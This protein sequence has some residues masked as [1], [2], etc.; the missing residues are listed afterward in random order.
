MSDERD[1][2]DPMAST[3]YLKEPKG[4]YPEVAVSC[5]HFLNNEIQIEQGRDESPVDLT[6][7][8]NATVSVSK[9][10]ALL[11]A[12]AINEYFA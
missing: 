2:I 6:S 12:K 9:E 7:F 10:Q 11:I 5:V 8:D 3:V 4:Q 1:V